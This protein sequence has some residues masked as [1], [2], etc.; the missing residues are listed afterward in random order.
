MNGNW[1][2]P[3]HEVSS[4]LTAAY[5]VVHAAG[6][7]TVLTLYDDIGCADGSSELT[8]VAFS[9]LYARSASGWA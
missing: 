2:G 6:G 4:E 8:P 7:K 9:R 3:Y 5:D 1:T